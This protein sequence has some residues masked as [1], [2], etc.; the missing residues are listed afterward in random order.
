MQLRLGSTLLVVG[1]FVIAGCSDELTRSTAPLDRAPTISA[2]PLTVSGIRDLIDDLVK[3]AN[4]GEAQG[5]FGKVED[6]L[7][8]GGDVEAAAQA[9]QTLMLGLYAAGVLDDPAPPATL[10][11]ELV[12]LMNAVFTHAGLT[13]FV[14]PPA[15]TDPDV[16]F[17]VEILTDGDYEDGKAEVKTNFGNAAMIVAKGDFSGPVILSII[18]KS[19]LDDEYEMPLPPGIRRI[20]KVF[21]FSTSQDIVLGKEVIV[22]ICQY[23]EN[24]GPAPKWLLHDNDGTVELKDTDAIG[25]ECPHEQPHGS[26]DPGAPLWAKGLHAVARVAGPLLSP[27]RLYASHS[28]AHR[29]E[30]LSPWS[31]G[32]EEDS[33]TMRYV[34][35]V[36]SPHTNTAAVFKRNGDFVFWL[37]VS[38][39]DFVMACNG[40]RQPADLEAAAVPNGFSIANATWVRSSICEPIGTTSGWK[41]S[42]PNPRINVEHSGKIHLRVEGTQ[43][44]MSL[45]YNTVR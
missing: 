19:Y 31:I 26:L 34:R 16:E 38:N 30:I 6:A 36:P 10:D 13:E 21:E 3:P 39:N 24:P 32:E 28:L 11:G 42:L 44:P 40:G 7:T 35:T 41:F 1:A 20:A 29:T 8:G 9:F 18:D 22:S 25:H 27:K 45:N 5:A 14:I 2:Q 4:M 23:L 43:I 12:R 15:P 37:E 17:V 33:F